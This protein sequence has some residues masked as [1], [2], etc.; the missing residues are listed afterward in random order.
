MQFSSMSRRTAADILTKM[1]EPR[2]RTVSSCARLFLNVEF[3]SFCLSLPYRLK[4]SNHEDKIILREA[5]AAR[6]PASVQ[7]RSKQGFGA[8][9]KRWFQDP[10]VRELERR[11]L[12]D[13]RA[14]VYE[15]ISY[16]G[17]QEILRRNNLMQRWTLLV[18]S[19][20]LAQAGKDSR[21]AVVS[22]QQPALAR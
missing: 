17:T 10:G 2:W 22:H 16:N 14:P 18:L 4:L 13:A 3:A 19:I 15:I 20:W 5:F 12:Q 21:G 1:I 11:F 6:W 8:P 7:T 9:L